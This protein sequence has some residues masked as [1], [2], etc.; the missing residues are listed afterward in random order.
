MLSSW[1]WRW[2]KGSSSQGTQAASRK[3][4]RQRSK[5]S[6]RSSRMEHTMLTSF[7]SSENPLGLPTYRTVKQYICILMLFTCYF[8]WCWIFFAAR[9][10]SSCCEGGLLSSCGARASRCDGSSCWEHGLQGTQVSVVVAHGLCSCS[11]RLW[12]AGSLV[13][14]HGLSCSTEC[15]IFSDQGQ[16][17]RLLHWK[18]DSLPLSHQGSLIYLCFFKSLDLC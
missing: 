12:S 11:S 15:A 16:N 17:V 5:A 3:W 8:W 1:L 18:A 2:S 6:P 4:K 7:Q 13:M 9:L 14:A 10:L